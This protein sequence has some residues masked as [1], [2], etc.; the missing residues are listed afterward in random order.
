MSRGRGNGGNREVSPPDL[1]S[2]RGDLSAAGA[3][4]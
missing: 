4:A 2:A 3:E 1:L